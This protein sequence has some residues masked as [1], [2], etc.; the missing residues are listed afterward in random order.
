VRSL[1]VEPPSSAA[2]HLALGGLLRSVGQLV[3]AADAQLAGADDD[4]A[5][6]WA[7]D[8]GILKVADRVRAMR[9]EAAWK[10]AGRG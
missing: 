9:L 6:R 4:E 2:T 3:V 10:A 1:V 7:R 5:A 8:R